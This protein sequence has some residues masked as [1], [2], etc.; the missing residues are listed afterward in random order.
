MSHNQS[1]INELAYSY[2]DVG[3]QA[4]EYDSIFICPID[5]SVHI[6]YSDALKHNKKTSRA[7]KYAVPD[8]VVVRRG[9]VDGII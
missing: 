4:E 3:G 8:V 6:S 7:L 5:M 9:E 2:F 1:E